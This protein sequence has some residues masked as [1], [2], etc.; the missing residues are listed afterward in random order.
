MVEALVGGLREA[1][2]VAR[3]ETT[4]R[5]RARNYLGWRC[6]LCIP[7]YPSFQAD[8]AFRAAA[9]AV[10]ATLTALVTAGEVVLVQA[11]NVNVTATITT[12]PS[13]RVMVSDRAWRH[14]PA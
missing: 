4:E 3:P 7:H 10:L 11:A 14:M 1:S 6:L 12:T 9:A 5:Q 2:P 13:L 8:S